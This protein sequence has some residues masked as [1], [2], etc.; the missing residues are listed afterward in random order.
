MKRHVKLFEEFSEDAPAPQESTRNVIWALIFNPDEAIY[1]VYQSQ[2][3]AEEAK[4]RIND[5]AEADFK[6]SYGQDVP[7]DQEEEDLIDLQSFMPGRDNETDAMLFTYAKHSGPGPEG[8]PGQDSKE[9]V[10]RLILAGGNP[11]ASSKYHKGF[12]RI[13][14]LERFFDGDLSWMPESVR[15]KMRRMKRSMQAFG[16]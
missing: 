13:E 15:A 9:V 5:Y 16:M 11:I 2:E 4:K 12:E 8:W 3:E 6:S 1:G 10:R 14:D 7:Y